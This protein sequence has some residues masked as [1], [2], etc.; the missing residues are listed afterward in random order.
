MNWAIPV[1]AVVVWAAF[2][3]GHYLGWRS[4]ERTQSS[5]LA[6]L[7]RILDRTRRQIDDIQRSRMIAADH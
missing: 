2:A 6:E 7:Q 5:D 4:R 1:S 3:L